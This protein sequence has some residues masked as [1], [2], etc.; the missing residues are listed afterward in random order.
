MWKPLF[1]W[2][3]ARQ[4]LGCASLGSTGDKEGIHSYVCTYEA[5][6]TLSGSQSAIKKRAVGKKKFWGLG[7]RF[8]TM[9]SYVY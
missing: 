4:A 8:N 9:K 6:N 2:G 5:H 3:R 1:F 7:L